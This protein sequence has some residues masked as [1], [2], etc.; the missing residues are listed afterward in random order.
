MRRHVCALQHLSESSKRTHDTLNHLER[1]LGAL[2]EGI[3][4]AV[5]I[6]G[7]TGHAAV[8]P[9]H[10]SHATIHA[11]ISSH[12]AIASVHGAHRAEAGVRRRVASVAA[13]RA[14]AEPGGRVGRVIGGGAIDN[15]IQ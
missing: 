5:G 6:V 14:C 12:A 3:R 2:A 15:R 13:V 9:P 8:H 11:A 4:Q 1:S 7:I 10:A